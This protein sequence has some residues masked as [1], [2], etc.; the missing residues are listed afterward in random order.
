MKSRKKVFR[1]DPVQGMK[2]IPLDFPIF[3]AHLIQKRF[4]LTAF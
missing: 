1:P 3:L 4:D 2:K